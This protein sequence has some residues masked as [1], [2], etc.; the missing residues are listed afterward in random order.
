M[1]DWPTRRSIRVPG[2]DYTS[3]SAYFVTLCTADRACIFGEIV[4]DTPTLSETGLIVD[5]EWRRSA[6]VRRNVTL[7]AYVIMPNHLHGVLFIAD[8]TDRGRASQRLAPTRT[9]PRNPAG[10]LGAVIGQFKSAVTKRVS[11]RAGASVMVWQRGY[12]EHIIR[13]DNG[14][15]RIRTYIA[16]NPARWAEDPENPNAC[17]STDL[18]R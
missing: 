12:Y 18:P 5:E 10:S 8:A 16:N 17:R 1:Q 13:D 15:D 11:S 3:A 7:D 2:H 9:G 14:L 4:D 6:H